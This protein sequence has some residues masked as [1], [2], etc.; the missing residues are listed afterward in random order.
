MLDTPPEEAFD[1]LVKL[2]AALCEVPISTVSLVDEDRQWFKAQVGL[3]SRETPIEVSFCKHAIQQDGLYVVEDA[4][5][6]PLFAKNA[7]VT[8]EPHI[9]FYAGHPLRAPEGEALGTLC[10]IDRRPR[11]LT[12]V[13]RQAL[14]VLA[15]QV[16]A[17][18]Q[19]K[20][21][22]AVLAKTV[23][24]RDEAFAA[25]RA[26]SE[27]AA[28][29]ER[30]AAA[31]VLD[32]SDTRFRLMVEGV[33]NHAL[34]TIDPNGN[35]SSWNRGGERML[36]YREEDIL[37]RSFACFF[38]PEDLANGL[39]ERQIALARQ[40]GRAD[41]EGWR[42]RAD[43]SRFWASVS[44]TALYYDS[45]EEYGFAVVIEDR[46]EERRIESAIEETRAESIRLQEKLLSHVSHE[47]RTPLTAIYFF[48]SNVADGL[49]GELLPE[50]R[51]HLKI[52]IENVNQLTEMVNDLLDITRAGTAK[53]SI[54]PHYTKPGKLIAKVGTT[55]QRNAAD[56]GVALESS[57]DRAQEELLP[58][59][60]A[61]ASRVRQILTNLIDNAIKFTPHGG[62]VRV[63]AESDAGDAGFVRFWVKDTGPGIRPE[64]RELIF[65]RLAQVSDGNQSSRAGLGLGLYIARELVV[66]HGGRI[67]L[68]SE[69]G[70]GSTF[71]FTL[72]V[73]S[74][75]R[76]C[77]SIFTE[78]NLA[79]GHV[80]L[81]SVDLVAGDGSDRAELMPQV[82][83]A[84][85]RC[86]RPGEDA[87]LPWMGDSD[88][89][90][91]VF[92]VAYTDE[93]GYE[94]MAKRIDK[95]L[96]KFTAGF[97]LQ[98]TVLATT[99]RFD[100]SLGMKAQV[101]QITEEFERLIAEHLERRESLHGAAGGVATER[102]EKAA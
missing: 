69:F 51:D 90:I 102:M 20:D 82:Q 39:P 63:G 41:D 101:D 47:L 49:L 1:E 58:A 59:V 14:A 100:R 64:H 11:H 77:A 28:E 37:G 73:F 66:Q 16:T 46:T 23:C 17:Q 54:E 91:T 72:P 3:D 94:A 71:S 96:R 19:L 8:G 9:R 75:A 70:K 81:I 26:A 95:E 40:N 74:L 62:S 85:A 57:L 78:E 88:S 60:W 25:A 30:I 13:Q 56:K 55:C 67:W 33:H 29:Q 21:R 12:P 99:I 87:L 36:G 92:I 4:T 7:L 45:P 65:E 44:K 68:E 32:K 18:I 48:T 35:I 15:H 98:P 83:N 80:T 27:R 38:T 5:C 34:L 2:A 89:L 6:D 42:V 97:A 24:E 76:L 50:Q 61:D 22:L 86:I 52:A 84:L 10:V 53:L 31:K 93:Q 79:A 43:G